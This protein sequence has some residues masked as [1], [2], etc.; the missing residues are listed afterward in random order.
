MPYNFFSVLL[1]F[2]NYATI[3]MHKKTLCDTQAHNFY[4]NL[5]IV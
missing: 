4:N 1:T 2:T 5:I 3:A